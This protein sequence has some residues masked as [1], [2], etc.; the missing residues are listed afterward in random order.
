M[1]FFAVMSVAC[2]LYVN[3][4]EHCDVRTKAVYKTTSHAECVLEVRRGTA[5]V[6]DSALAD[7]DVVR[8]VAN[9]A[10]CY[11][12]TAELNTKEQMLPMFMEATGR[13]YVLTRY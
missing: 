5:K 13:T 3:G 6:A 11:S 1:S 12:S 7:P 9:E 10:Y 4:Q 2:V 8:I